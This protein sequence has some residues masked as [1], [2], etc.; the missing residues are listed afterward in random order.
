M[1]GDAIATALRS[2]RLAALREWKRLREPA[3]K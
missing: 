3:K 1:P 2:A